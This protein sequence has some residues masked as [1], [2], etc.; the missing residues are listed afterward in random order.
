[1]SRALVID[2]EKLDYIESLPPSEDEDQDNNFNSNNNFQSDLSAGLHAR[3]G[4]QQRVHEQPSDGALRGV[5]AP[6]MEDDSSSISDSSL[7]HGRFAFYH[8]HKASIRHL[9]ALLICTGLFI[10][11]VVIHKQGSVLVLSL[12]Y[13]AIVWW[14]IVQHLPEGTISG[15]VSRAWTGSGALI[16]KMLPLWLIRAIGY[17]VPPVALILTAA[18][19]PS[20][21]HGTRGQRLIS[22]LGLVVLLLLMIASSKVYNV[23]GVGSC[24]HE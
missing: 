22:C 19:R 14:L 20:D 4:Y 2:D 13:A 15:P 18:L 23:F 12:L 3:Q 1:M 8:Q 6:I 11:A 9:L 17:G 24:Q 5:N 7:Y 16:R 10:P 21:S